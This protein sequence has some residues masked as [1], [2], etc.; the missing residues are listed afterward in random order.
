MRFSSKKTVRDGGLT[1]WL[2]FV[3]PWRAQKHPKTIKKQAENSSKI[4]EPK[5]TSQNSK[6]GIK[7]FGP[8]ECADRWGGY[9]GGSKLP[10]LEK[11]WKKSKTEMEA[12][13]GEKIFEDPAGIQHADP[14]GGGSLR[15]FR[16][17]K[18]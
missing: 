6:R 3:V 7:P 18:L 14:R 4:K 9:G 13:D 15:A 2:D 12:K 10:K 11:I 8:A 5:K 16:G 1:F 17:A